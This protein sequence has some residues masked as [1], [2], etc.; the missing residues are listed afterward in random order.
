[1]LVLQEFQD[2]M[3]PPERMVSMEYPELLERMAPQE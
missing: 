2:K 1:M 3:D